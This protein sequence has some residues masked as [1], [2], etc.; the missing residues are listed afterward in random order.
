VTTDT[1]I[2]VVAVRGA[3]TFAL[4]IDGARQGAP[5]PLPAYIDSD[6]A[7][8]LLGHYPPA[9]FFWGDL[10]E[11]TFYDRELI[12]TEV[13]ALHAAGAAGKCFPSTPSCPSVCDA[14]DGSLTSCPCS[15]PG[16]PET[17]CDIQQGTGGV[18]LSV[19]SQEITPQNRVTWSGTGFPAASAPASI[20]IRAASLDPGSPIPFGDG[21]R[22]IGTPLVRL[23]ATF[24][25][26]GAVTHAHGHGSMAGSGA[27]YYQLWFR[28]TPAMYCDPAAAFNLSNGRILTW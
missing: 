15:N 9:S 26:G 21:L 24:A 27:F 8:V 28:N 5:K 4:Y 17:G 11:I 14:S 6:T 13:S 20:V 3:S 12:G 16:N 1:W 22:C 23:A 19:V 10:D 7:D 25:S 18:G 2:H